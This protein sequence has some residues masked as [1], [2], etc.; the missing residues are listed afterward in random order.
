MKDVLND[1]F[2]YKLLSKETAQ[3]ILKNLAQGAY[4]NS[5]VASF[6][7]VY[8][9]RSITVEELAG[10]GRNLLGR[11][12]AL[13]HAELVHLGQYRFDGGGGAAY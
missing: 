1:L 7:T 11:L 6:L 4:N 10:S 3:E 2:E 8:L 9:M 12:D 13:V 5:Q